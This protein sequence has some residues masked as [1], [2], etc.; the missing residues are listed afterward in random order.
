MGDG[1]EAHLEAAEAPRSAAVDESEDE[2]RAAL[3]DGAKRASRAETDEAH[4]ETDEGAAPAVTDAD[5]LDDAPAS[6]DDAVAAAVAGLDA[7]LEESQRLQSRQSD[8][9]DRLHAENQ[10]LKAGELRAAQLPLVRDLLRLHD[11]LAR[12]RVAASEADGDLRVVQESLS[13]TL[14]RNGIEAYAPAPGEPFDPRLHSA[15]GV[16][17][18]EEEAL[19]KTVA[20]VTRQGFRWA[21]GETIRVAEVRAHRYRG[22]D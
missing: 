18:T 1:A 13:D 14:A 12:M 2:D 9:I 21:S 11:D 6:G 10:Q 17:L 22:A 8:L 5:G 7:R 20:E 15:A 19:D 4:V 16:E 3:V